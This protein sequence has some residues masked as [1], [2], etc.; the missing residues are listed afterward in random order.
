M[1]TQNVTKSGLKSL[2][3]GSAGPISGYMSRDPDISFEVWA[4][5]AARKGW[6]IVVDRHVLGTLK[7]QLDAIEYAKAAAKEAA[8]EASL[9]T[10]VVRCRPGGERQRIAVFGDPEI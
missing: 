8:E 6:Q 9:H 7:S 1:A 10:I 5:D 2:I 4:P 3:F